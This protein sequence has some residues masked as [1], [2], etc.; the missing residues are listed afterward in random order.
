M[1]LFFPV[2]RNYHTAGYIYNSVGQP[3]GVFQLV[4]LAM[5]KHGQTTHEFPD[6]AGHYAVFVVVF[7]Q[8]IALL[9]VFGNNGLQ[10]AGAL[11][12]ILGS[13]PVCR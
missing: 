2:S 7:K 12:G 1:L 10:Q 11:P 4:G 5:G 8:F 9:A 3:D 13:A 6:E